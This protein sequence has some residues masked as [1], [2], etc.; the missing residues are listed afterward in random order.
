MRD[1]HARAAESEPRKRRSEH[2]LVARLLVARVAHGADQILST[3]TDGGE[4]ADV[5]VRGRALVGRPLAR[6]GRPRPAGIREAATT[7]PGKVSV[8]VGSTI[9]SEGLSMGD[10]MPVFSP[11]DFRSTIAMPVVSLPVPHVLGQAMCGLSR[12]GIGFALPMG[13]LT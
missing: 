1:V 7:P 11:T 4:A 6:M 8:V 3:E 12:P 10:A 2:E 13:A 5:V 9:A